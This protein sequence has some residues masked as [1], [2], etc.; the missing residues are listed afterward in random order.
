MT[1]AGPSRADAEFGQDP[2]E[3]QKPNGSENHQKYDVVPAQ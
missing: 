1:G 3:Q 2:A